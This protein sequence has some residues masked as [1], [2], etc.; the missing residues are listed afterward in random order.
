MTVPAVNLTELDGALGILPVSSGKLLAIIGSSSAG[1]ENLPAAFARAKDVVA[2]FTSGPLVE[3]ASYAIE[4]YGKPVVLVRSEDVTVGGYGSIVDGVTGTSVP[5]TNTATEPFDQYEVQIDII[6]GGTI[7]VSGITYQWSIDGG[8][9]MSATTALGTAAFILLSIANVRVNFAAGTLIAGDT[10]SFRTSAPVWDTTTLDTALD[11]LV[12]SKQPWECVAVLGDM[13]SGAFSTVG[14]VLDSAHNA[15]KHRWAMVHT[16]IPTVGESDAT[17]QASVI[18]A[19]ANSTHTSMALVSG[20]AK[21]LSSVTR[22]E[23]R[24][25][26]VRALAPRFISVSEEIDPAAIDLGSLPGVQITDDNG[27]PDDHDEYGN[28]GLDSAGFMVLRTWENREGAF[29]NR[30]KI[31]CPAGSDYQT[32]MLRRV[33]NIART[34]LA[35]YLQLRL[36]KPIL[37]DRKTGFI[38]EQEARDIESGA[39]STLR[40]TLLTKPKASDANFVLSRVDNLLSTGELNGEARIIP[41]GYPDTI[42]VSIGF[43]NPAIQAV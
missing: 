38:L 43:N 12:A 6:A 1:P 5:T 10:L 7:G 37:V 34:A 16:R 24:C 33:M 17:Y 40:T 42:T 8:R 9:T 23:Y 14:A 19:F 29:L 39:N 31:K 21:I 18:A 2:N 32:V 15:G 27:N 30:S 20:S 41:L 11:A 4:R 36:H 28:P 13:T 25:S 35:S 22:R 3:A 26:P